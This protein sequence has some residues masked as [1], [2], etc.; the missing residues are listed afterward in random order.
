VSAYSLRQGKIGATRAR[1]KV[2][3][4]GTTL[5][6]AR[7]RVWSS[8]WTTLFSGDLGRRRLSAIETESGRN[9]A[10]EGERVRVRARLK[11]ELGEWAGNMAD[12]IGV[13]AHVGHG[14]CGEDEADWAGPWRRG[15][16]AR[17]GKRFSAYGSGPLHRGRARARARGRATPTDRAR[18]AEGGGRVR[19]GAS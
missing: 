2:P 11:R 7:R 16:G 5:G 13:C 8:G 17:E 15:T 19:A 14:G 9:E 3:H 10:G 6:E 12:F 4:L 1:G 18:L